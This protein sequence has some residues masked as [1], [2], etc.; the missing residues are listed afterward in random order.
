MGCAARFY[1]TQESAPCPARCASKGRVPDMHRLGCESTCWPGL[2]FKLLGSFFVRRK[3]KANE[4]RLLR[5]S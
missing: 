1:G 3:W 2:R 4:A 5:E